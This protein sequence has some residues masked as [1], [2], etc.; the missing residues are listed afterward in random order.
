MDNFQ[1]DLSERPPVR[2]GG[3][4]PRTVAEVDLDFLDA[5]CQGVRTSIVAAVA[6][7]EVPPTPQKPKLPEA[8]I[9]STAG[10]NSPIPCLFLDLET[11]PDEERSELFGLPEIAP[12]RETPQADCVAPEEVI[13]W[14]VERIEEYVGRANP[15]YTWLNAAMD[16]E[17]ARGK[18]GEKAKPRDGVSK[19]LKKGLSAREAH[20]AQVSAQRKKMA[21]CPEMCRIV[22]VGWAVGDNPPRS[23]LLGDMCNE[24][25]SGK[26]IDE[27]TILQAIWLLLSRYR[28]IVGFNCLA[29]DLQVIRARSVILGV[30]PSVVLS[31]SPYTNRDVTDL[32][33]RRFGRGVPDMGLKQLARLYG[34]NVPSSEDGSQ[35]DR[36]LSEDRD[37][38]RRYVESDIHITRELFRKWRG[39][40]TMTD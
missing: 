36:L 38:L 33:T 17:Q 25:S 34:V 11:V 27:R 12:F 15:E 26:P 18:G 31:D 30:L 1:V 23:L 35:I 8:T 39:I 3:G 6:A 16:L 29:F 14:S 37:G 22:A 4:K 9:A 2:A 7:V 13:G 21:T 5:E 20:A 40:W 28:P 19:I 10:I 24:F 32:A